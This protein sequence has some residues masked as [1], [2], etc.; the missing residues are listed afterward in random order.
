LGCI[1][2]ARG[3]VLLSDD[4]SYSDGDLTTQSGGAWANHSGSG[5]FVQVNSGQ[6]QLN[7]GSGSREDVNRT[8]SSAQTTGTVY[9]GF[10]FSVSASGTIGGGDY[11]Y[12]AHFWQ[13]STSF[14]G[15]MDIV[16][17]SGGGDYTV[18]ISTDGGTADS[19]WATDLTF[20]TVYRAIIG[21]DLDVDQAQLWIDPTSPSSTSILGDDDNT[22]RTLNAFGFRQSTSSVNESITIDNLSV[23]T[24]F[25][26]VPEPSRAV[27]GL[28][29]LASL[30]VRRRRR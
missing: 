8:V 23:A 21:F 19:T 2:T 24:E 15:R 14:F 3:T 1:E 22:S 30:G 12:F 28:I 9:A 27:L 6:I 10:D 20:D 4:F 5:T 26:Q 29:A 17:P 11:E 25:Y 16:N 7:H 13:G 18:G